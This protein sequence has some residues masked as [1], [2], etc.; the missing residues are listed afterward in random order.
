M[1]VCR[2]GANLSHPGALWK[3]SC[4]PVHRIQHW[5]EIFMSTNLNQLL[6]VHGCLKDISTHE[7]WSY[8]LVP[9]NEFHV[10]LNMFLKSEST[11]CIDCVHRNIFP[12]KEVQIICSG[13]SERP[14]HIL[15]CA[16]CYF[17][18]LNYMAFTVLGVGSPVCSKIK[19]L[20]HFLQTFK[21]PRGQVL[22]KIVIPWLFPLAPPAGE[23]SDIHSIISQ[24]L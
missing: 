6:V 3:Q 14:S 12:L 1:I 19:Y 23:S 15:F 9:W 21:F 4:W 16:S 2:T 8:N 5:H 13:V 7:M 10:L 22:L 17:S 24:R 20:V 11:W 18:Y